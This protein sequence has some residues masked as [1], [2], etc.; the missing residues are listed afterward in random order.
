MDSLLKSLPIAISFVALVISLYVLIT[1]KRQYQL[2]LK[3]YSDLHDYNRRQFTINLLAKWDD[4]TLAARKCVMYKWQQAF[5]K[6]DDINW[7]E[8]EKY[9]D[10]QL[11]ELK[12][13]GESESKAM[14]ITDH[15][16][17][18]LNYFDLIAIS[19]E[20]NI[21]DEEI[22]KQA[23]LNTFHRWYIIL[24]D[25]R[26]HVNKKRGYHPWS[27]LEYLHDQKWFISNPSIKQTKDATG[28]IG[29]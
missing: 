13:K 16:G 22:M 18:I 10:E 23:M 8:I 11:N 6:E 3:S 4:S 25:Y 9:R 28:K 20:N 17:T 21:V 29:K 26:E 5:Y 1:A 12:T 2:A 14:V 7:S 15:M 24:S 19:I 27:M